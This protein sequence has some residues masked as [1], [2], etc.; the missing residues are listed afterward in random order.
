[1]SPYRHAYQIYEIHVALPISRRFI[2]EPVLESCAGMDVHEK[3]VDVCIAHGPLG[4]S[5]KFEIRTFS[6]MTSDLEE[7]TIWLKKYNVKTVGMESTGVYWKP[8]FNVMEGEFTIVLANAQR[9]K[10]IP[11]KKTD[12]MDCKRIAKLLRYGLLPNSFIP[13]REIRELRD[14]NRTRRKLVGMMT[15][16][17][18]RLTKV[19]ESSNIKLSSVVSKISGVSSMAMIR[20]LLEKDRLSKEEISQLAKGSLKKKVALLEKALNGKVTDH[21]RFLLKMH[22]ENLDHLARQI[23]KIDEEIERK[24]IPFQKEAKLIQTIPGISK[25]SASAILAEIG[26]DMSQ[27][28]DEAHLSSWAGVCPGN[29][30]SAGKKKSG[31]TQKG[32]SFLKGTLAEAAWAASKTKR[33]SYSAFYHN[34]V[35]RRGK[36]RALVAL[37]HRMLADI[38]HVLKTGEPYQ[39]TG[40]E[41]ANERATKRREQSM[42]RSLEKAGYSIVKTSIAEIA[43]A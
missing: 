11:R 43:V 39:D 22:L 13:P 19:L 3:K 34:I 33:T 38:Y 20:S 26:T 31:K 35:R 21:H 29:N 30:E 4:K 23:E 10:A 16:E 27:F 25:V 37:A 42:I 28:P 1:M 8:I 14:L 40:A 32:N 9:L 24:M 5:P 6:T 12:I 41:A 18:N 36:K 15:S 7:L 17:K 2:M